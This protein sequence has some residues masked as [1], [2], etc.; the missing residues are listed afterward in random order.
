[1]REAPIAGEAGRRV[2]DPAPAGQRSGRILL[3]ED[4]P[5]LRDI[6]QR[7]LAR[8][9]FDVTPA[10]GPDEAI[11]AAE[12]M[13]E[14]IDLLVTDVVMPGMRGPEL[15]IRLRSSRPGLPVLL[16][17]GY[18]EEIVEG[19]RD[20]SLPFLAKPFSAESLLAAV[21]GAL[22]PSGRLDGGRDSAP[23]DGDA[24]ERA[25]STAVMVRSG[26]RSKRMAR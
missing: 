18:A 26:P 16:V 8:A 5:G 17:S 20:D 24:A 1:M 15:A 23:G 11:L 14:S 22:S 9:G 21:D 25:G 4:E 10:A 7:V 19:Q 6:A 2:D 13:T 3:V 12:A